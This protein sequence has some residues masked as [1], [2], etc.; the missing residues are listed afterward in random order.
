MLERADIEKRMDVVYAARLHSAKNLKIEQI[1]APTP[2][3][4]QVKIRFRAGGIC[5]SDLSYYFKG[6][7]G[8]FEVKEPFVLGHEFAG[9]VVELGAGVSKIALGQRVAVNPSVACNECAFC[10]AGFPNQCLDMKFMGSAS[11]FPHR[12]GGFREF[13]CVSASQCFPVP[14]SVS[15][16][17]ASMAE[18]LAVSL[19]CIRRC[20]SLVGARLLIIGC[21]PIGAILLQAA[22][23]AGAHHITVIDISS[24]ALAMAKK[25]GAD[26]TY[27]ATDSSLAA[28][29]SKNRGTF[30]VVIEASGSAP[31]LDTALKAV[32]A[33]G[34]VVQMGNLPSGQV[35]VAAN[36][37]MAKEISYIGTFRFTD[38]EYAAAVEEI[39]SRK[40]DLT[41][42]MTH[43]FPM[44]EIDK[45]FEVAADRSQSMKVHLLDL[46]K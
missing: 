18:P 1:E 15:Y 43:R 8:D 28:N 23:R 42:I 12:Q 33:R 40:I 39:A 46:E 4:G 11:V 25:L 7:S 2:E 29:W 27:D 22:R 38:A 13:V 26:E 36:L 19:H 20:G 6:R 31:G 35:P 14:D 37:I 45:A 9:E 44:S 17:E 16:A 10:L 3:A 32:K 21:G 30:D 5:G 24:E 41:A 34:R